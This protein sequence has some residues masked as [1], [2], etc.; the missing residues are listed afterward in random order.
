[1]HLFE[2]IMHRPVIDIGTHMDSLRTFTTNPSV[3]TSYFL[4][5]TA[6]QNL[7]RSLLPLILANPRCAMFATNDI[8]KQTMAS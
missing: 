5:F 1:M 4:S 2:L 3:F 7:N 8:R 6:G